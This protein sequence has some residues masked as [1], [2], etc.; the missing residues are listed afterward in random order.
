MAMI[1]TVQDS[2]AP[3]AAPAPRP[4]AAPPALKPTPVQGA[5]DYVAQ[6]ADPTII[7]AHI[8]THRAL[9]TAMGDLKRQNEL[10]M[11]NAHLREDVERMTRHDLKS[12]IA[13]TLQA[14]QALARPAPRTWARIRSASWPRPRAA[15]PPRRR[16][17]GTRA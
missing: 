4:G 15:T 2:G 8:A 11:E 10:L 12:P 17:T 13:V 16:E 3:V 5:V 7:K 14:G 9:A 1:G 6:P